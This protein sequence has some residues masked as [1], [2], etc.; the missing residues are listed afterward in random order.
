MSSIL[1]ENAAVLDVEQGEILPDRWVLV[2]GARIA[3][4]SE[5]K[6]EARDVRRIDLKGQT[7]MP[8]LIDCHVHVTAFTANF[9][10]LV[11]TPPSYVAAKSAEIM[12][13]M[14]RRGFTTV[15]DVGGADHGL[16]RAVDEGLYAAPRLFFCG[17]ALSPTGGH[18]DIRS[19]GT[20][21]FERAY[22]QPGLGRIADGV[23]AVRQA[24]RDEIRRGAHHIKIMG[25]G[26][27]SSPTDR[28]S[29]DQYSEEEIAA[30]VEE[31]AM[32]NLYVAVHSYA[33]RSI[34][35][36]VRLG[37]RSIEHGNLATRETIDL[38]KAHG[39]V[40]VPTLSVFRAL[41]EEGVEAG[42]PKDLVGKTYEVLDAGINAVEMAYRAGVPMAFGTDLLGAM[43]RRQLDEFVLRADVVKAADL[44]RAATINGARLIGRG[45]EFGLVKAG[46]LADLIVV[47]GNP[48]D[49]IRIMADPQRSPRLVMK[50]GQLFLN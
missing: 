40:L 50:G 3:G 28:I 9:A 38:M 7:L 5:T 30:V 25:G 42:L 46:Y 47:D 32:A 35:R 23:A 17:K 11:Q 41:V 48:L 18:G 6:P 44:V 4:I 8:G 29:S 1:F 14:L 10:E 27:I 33:A 15:R 13:G 26:G 2:E 45:H 39:A 34:E 37:V 24:A 12:N 49:N 20:D 22:T 43:H 19:P 31:A 21:V 16:A 36:C